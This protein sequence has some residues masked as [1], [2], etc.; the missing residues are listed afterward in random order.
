MGWT[1]P[2]KGERVTVRWPGGLY[3][4]VL[5][6]GWAEKVNGPS[7]STDD[8]YVVHGLVVEPSAPEHRSFRG[9]YSHRTGPREYTMLPH[10]KAGEVSHG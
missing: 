5:E 4:F 7:W 2:E 8:W 3:D 10:R 6:F 9:L 1:E